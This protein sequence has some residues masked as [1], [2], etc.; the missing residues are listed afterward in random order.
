LT[1]NDKTNKD[2]ARV[3]APGGGV[4]FYPVESIKVKKDNPDRGYFTRPEGTELLVRFSEKR[5][6]VPDTAPESE[7]YNNY[8]KTIK[9]EDL[10][11]M[12][13]EERKAFADQHGFV[14]MTVPTEWG[15]T[16]YGSD[17]KPYVSVSISIKQQDK[18]VYYSF[19]MPAE[20]FKASERDQGMSYFGYPIKNKD[21]GEDFLVT[22]RSSE[23]DE[24]GEYRNTDINVPSTKLK[25]YVED[26]LER[27]R[28]KHLFVSTEIS[29]KLT[30]SFTSNS[31]KELVAVSV[32]VYRDNNSDKA[33]FYEIVV[34]AER[35]RDGSKDGYV[36]LS[37][38]RDGP[39]GTE[40]NFNAKK[41]VKTVDGYTDETLKMTSAEVISHFEESAKRFRDAHQDDHSLADEMNGKK[42]ENVPQAPRH[43][44]R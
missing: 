13:E 28:G 17:Q 38:F 19:I 11:S 21:T 12:Y 6:G 23:K 36:K 10:K 39:D 9:I 42:P 26:A 1:H 37:L 2:Y 24:N 18:D 40:Y 15:R 33:D 4:I 44:G 32:P 3:Y 31:G 25:E 27:S 5:E 8:S 22:L 14:N 7:K 43:H 16:F 41:S 35:I 29:E 34:P 20:R 30:R